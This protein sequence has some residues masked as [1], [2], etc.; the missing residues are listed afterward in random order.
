MG[1]I[2]ATTCDQNREQKLESN[3]NHNLPDLISPNPDEQAMS[4]KARR[5]IALLQDDF[6]RQSNYLHFDDVNRMI[7]RL[8][9]K[10]EDVAFVW[11]SLAASNIVVDG[12][13][14]EDHETAKAPAEDESCE[15]DN[16]DTG[17][18]GDHRL[19]N[20]SQ[21]IQL[22]RRVQAGQQA[23]AA[24]KLSGGSNDYDRIVQL[25]ENAKATLIL[26]NIRLVNHAATKFSRVTLIPFEDLVQ[27]GILGLFRAVEKYDPERGFRFSTYATWWIN[28]RISRSICNTGRTVRIP[29][30]MM[31]QLRKLKRKRRS[32]RD[33][34]G[35]KPFPSELSKELGLELSEIALLTQIA[36]D[37]MQLDVSKSPAEFNTDRRGLRSRPVSPESQAEQKELKGIVEDSLEM[38][39][40]RSKMIVTKRFGLDGKKPKTLKQLGKHLGITRERVRQIQKRALEKISQGEHRGELR[41]YFGV[42]KLTEKQE[43]DV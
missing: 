25:G 2:S 3:L 42:E 18:Y 7:S 34:L 13:E 22:G 5:C 6:E 20:H 35:R 8:Q 16:W 27:E 29:V 4:E 10:A 1:C 32:L 23:T 21:E 40:E 39:D 26:S 28:Q 19:L 43:D 33:E 17:G 24:E 36:K 38:L 31:K 9:L 41:E 14:P 15:S 12:L 37:A 30:H 11:E